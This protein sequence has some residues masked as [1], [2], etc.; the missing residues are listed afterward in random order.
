MAR[1]VID[2]DKKGSKSFQNENFNLK[3]FKKSLSKNEN[4]MM[5]FATFEHGSQFNII[6]PL[7]NLDLHSF[8]RGEY[9]DFHQRSAEFT[10]HSL[11]EETWCLAFALEFLHQGL[12]LPSGRVSLAHLD[13]K[14]ENILVEWSTEPV[15]T[16]PGSTLDLPVGRW[17]ISDFGISVVNPLDIVEGQSGFAA[18][19]HLT[20]GDVIREKSMKP[21]RDSG[22]F[23]APEMQKNKG[24]RVSTLSDRWSFGCIVTMILAFTLGGPKKVKELY[25]CRNEAY[26]DDYFYTD[27]PADG[28]VVKSEIK[29]WL[30]DQVDADIYKTHR[31]WISKCHE[32]IHGL[33]SIDKRQRLPDAGERL[34][35]IG[36]LIGNLPI[37]E[38]RRLWMPEP[39][40]PQQ[41]SDELTTQEP[42]NAVIREHTPKSLALTVPRVLTQCPP[43]GDQAPIQLLNTPEPSTFAGLEVPTDVTQT[44]LSACGSRVAFLS[45]TTVYVYDLDRLHQ[46][47]E[48]WSS[49]KAAKRIEKKSVEQSFQCFHCRKTRQ[50]TS[51]LLAG[52]FIALASTS[53]NSNDYTVRSPLLTRSLGLFLT[54]V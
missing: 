37:G 7:A 10:P 15:S 36:V 4:I 45:P 19:Q 26:S 18:G 48:R 34:L 27:T 5:S 22:P 53:R 43:S 24:L 21:P 12:A 20:P 31:E 30:S 47:K 32:L 52:P 25:K 11:F 17:K 1:K 54:M 28:P 8:L 35:K 50:W 29:K 2:I 3:Q 39:I 40:Q 49:Q 38:R 9:R 23:Q 51:V 41:G 14:P 33:L 6:S 42:N 16:V 13:L 46:Q 44:A